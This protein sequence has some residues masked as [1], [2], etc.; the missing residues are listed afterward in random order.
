MNDGTITN[1]ARLLRFQHSEM[2]QTELGS[3]IG[4]TGQTIAAMEGGKHSPSLET[5]FRIALVFS[6]KHHDV[7]Q[8]VGKWPARL[9]E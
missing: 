7:F 6:V 3:R 4:V 5:T 1:H 2:S 9:Q 8:C